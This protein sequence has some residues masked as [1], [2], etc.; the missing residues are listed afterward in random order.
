MNLLMFHNILS[1]F[2][3]CTEPCNGHRA[4]FLCAILWLAATHVLGDV[5]SAHLASQLARPERETP[6]ST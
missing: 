3:V 5:Y 4:R 2:L 6:I 1:C